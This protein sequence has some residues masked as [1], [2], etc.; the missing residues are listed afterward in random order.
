MSS[1][2]P[3]LQKYNTIAKIYNQVWLIAIIFAVGLF[4]MQIATGNI[5]DKKDSPVTSDFECYQ[6]PDEEIIQLDKYE[7]Q[8][9][10]EFSIIEYNQI[11]RTKLTVNEIP[12]INNPKF[13]QKHDEVKKCINNEE[14]V[15][16]LE[17]L[18][19][20]K[21]Y[22]LKILRQH[23]VINDFL[24]D[25]PI[26]VSF[27]ALCNSPAVYE[28]NL[29]DKTFTFGTTGL[30]YRN[31]D[32]FYDDLTD[33]LWSQLNG[34][35]VV[36]DS[37]GQ[38]LT[39]KNFKIMSIKNAVEQYPESK[40]MTFDTGFRRNYQDKSFEDYEENKTTLSEVINISEEFEVKDT[41]YAFE[42]GDQIY[43][44]N[45]IDAKKEDFSIK[46]DE[47]TNVSAISEDGFT[48]LLINNQETQYIQS[49][50]YVWH[51]HYPET[52]TLKP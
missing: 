37:V 13:T 49:Y 39:R 26:L 34:K 36:G 28:R 29:K 18:D 17:G 2:N 50:W 11:I 35:A 4:V 27:C 45:S 32:L 38:S 16:V 33:S 8:T 1:K 46:I 22:P 24:D 12:P 21:I 10:T 30:L 3:I 15:I 23:L 31:N 48:K 5:S 43:A 51:D 41:V 9:N 40:L 6:T 42:L 52:I 20:T 44:L 19:E 14:N 7:P 47:K 25:E